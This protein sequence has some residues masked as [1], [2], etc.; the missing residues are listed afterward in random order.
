MGFITLFFLSIGLCFDTFAVSV[1]SG[2]IRKEII[3]WQAVRIAFILALFQ[4][5]MPVFGWV[6]GITIRNW[7]EPFDHWVALGILTLLGVKM[8]IESQKN[9]DDKKI[10]P[11]DIK[12]IISMALATSID[13]FAVG[14]SF[15]IIQVN[16][17][18]A[19]MVIGTV[20]FV[21]SMLGILFGKKTGSHFG[22]KMEIIGGLILIAIGVKI[23][24]EHYQ[25]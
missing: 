25:A 24:I 10:N 20:T 23:V 12:V 5:V 22:K 4:A 19:F 3:F 6:G 21:I 1:S 17:L 9:S 11:L 15:A 13:A 14:I 18:M 2:L 16:M 7:I 8:L